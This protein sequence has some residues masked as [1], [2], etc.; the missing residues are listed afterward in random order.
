[1]LAN[2]KK[3]KSPEKNPLDLEKRLKEHYPHPNWLAHQEER[4]KHRAFQRADKIE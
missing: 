3:L 2:R 4:A 1:M